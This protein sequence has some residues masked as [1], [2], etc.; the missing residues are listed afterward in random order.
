MHF[1]LTCTSF[2]FVL[3]FNS[4][5]TMGNALALRKAMTIRPSILSSRFTGVALSTSALRLNRAHSE[6]SVANTHHSRK[7]AKMFTMAL[8][9]LSTM[10]SAGPV[11][12]P[13]E[14]FRLDYK[15]LPYTTSDVYMDFKLG[16]AESTV[17][18]KST[19]SRTSSN[20]EDLVF[21]GKQFHICLFSD[22]RQRKK[23]SISTFLLQVKIR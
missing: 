6:F 1:G 19:I 3:V 7:K 9:M 14:Y 8:A 10:V 12:T 15:P 16:L 17:T 11:V 23:K 18:T 21:N 20:V 5:V 13:V 2:V 22:L 4:F